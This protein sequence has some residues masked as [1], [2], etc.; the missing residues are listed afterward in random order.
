MADLP[1]GQ[2]RL[3]KSSSK[4]TATLNSRGNPRHIKKNGELRKEGSGGFVTRTCAPYPRTKPKASLSEYAGFHKQLPYQR[5]LPSGT[6]IAR[7]KAAKL[8]MEYV[9]GIHLTTI[10]QIEP[11]DCLNALKVAHRSLPQKDAKALVEHM[12]GGRV[13][14]GALKEYTRKRQALWTNEKMLEVLT[15]SNSPQGVLSMLKKVDPITFKK[16]TKEGVA[17]ELKLVQEEMEQ[18]GFGLERTPGSTFGLQVKNPGPWIELLTRVNREHGELALACDDPSKF[19]PLPPTTLNMIEKL[20]SSSINN[21]SPSTSELLPLYDIN[22]QQSQATTPANSTVPETSVVPLSFVLG[23]DKRLHHDTGLCVTECGISSLDVPKQ[24]GQLSLAKWVGDDNR[25]SINDHLKPNSSDVASL[26]CKINKLITEG[27]D[28]LEKH[29]PLAMFEC[30]DMVAC[31]AI[32]GENLSPIGDNFNPWCDTVQSKAIP[33]VE[34]KDTVLDKETCESFCKRNHINESSIKKLNPGL[35]TDSNGTPILQVGTQVTI[36]KTFMRNMTLDK[37]LTPLE[38][39]LQSYDSL[40]A[41]KAV[42]KVQ[43]KQFYRMLYTYDRQQGY[44]PEWRDCPRFMKLVKILEQ[45]DIRVREI[46]LKTKQQKYPLIK[47]YDGNC[48]VADRIQA[49]LPGPFVDILKDDEHV[50][51]VFDMSNTHQGAS[52]DNLVSMFKVQCELHTLI[53]ET[54]V[55]MPMDKRIKA[56]VLG[57]EFFISFKNAWGKSAITPYVW[58]VGMLTLDIMLH[59]RVP[60]GA[61]NTQRLEG[62]HRCEKSNKTQNGG[63][64]NRLQYADNAEDNAELRRAFTIQYIQLRAHNQKRQEGVKK[65]RMV[66]QEVRDSLSEFCVFNEF[67]KDNY[68]TKL[69]DNDK[70]LLKEGAT[71]LNKA[72]VCDADYKYVKQ[73]MK[74]KVFEVGER[75]KKRRALHRPSGSEP[76]AVNVLAVAGAQQETTPEMDAQVARVCD[77]VKNVKEKKW[78]KIKR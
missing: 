69:M 41:C 37:K 44:G 71:L 47:Y 43:F 24:V 51:K 23:L 68:L 16:V 65:R 19:P 60:I 61:M 72:D 36:F 56:G 62:R 21:D 32:N 67:T 30:H 75:N 17:H 8:F 73:F 74:N 59:T 76:V 27:V 50:K 7:K 6:R 14:E 53:K 2:P 64:V 9:A 33:L 54:D 3:R 34:T 63:G 70:T 55:N 39:F 20:N 49:L 1:P 78:K 11:D 31:C 18:K 35:E 42:T 46:K 40:H 58:T 5:A 45:G 25:D 13:L 52:Y 48:G 57:R 26:W 22:Q 29:F 38:I 28:C 10:D 66:T 77:A 4:A 12:K 15:L